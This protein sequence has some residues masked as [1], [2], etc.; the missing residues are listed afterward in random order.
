MPASKFSGKRRSK[1]RSA[2]PE[3][4][5][6]PTAARKRVPWPGRFAVIFGACFLL[7]FGVLMLPPVQVVDGRFSQVLVA[8]SHELIIICGGKATAQGAILQ[9]PSGF[10]VEMRDGCNAVNVTILLWAAVIAFPATWR[11]R[12][13]GA[14]GGS[15]VIQ[16]V[17]VVRFIT[18]FYIGQYSA[19]WFDFAH[20]YLWESLIVLDTMVIFWLWVSRVSRTANSPNASA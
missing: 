15:L 2:D 18:L 9:A 8:L 17:N 6:G 14:L 1:G 13:L 10:A 19:S 20:G 4:S 12:V 3:A 5:A 7:G 11:M 16:A